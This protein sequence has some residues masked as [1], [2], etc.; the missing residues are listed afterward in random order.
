[1]KLAISDVNCVL[2][3]DQLVSPMV[4]Q[5]VGG[6]NCE[7]FRGQSY[8]LSYYTYPPAEVSG[9]LIQGS[10]PFRYVISSLVTATTYFVRVAAVNSVAVQQISLDGEPPD[11]RQWSFPLSVT[12]KD[13]APDAPLAVFLYPFSGTTLELQIQPSTRDGK[14]EGGAA[15]TAFWIDIDTVSTFDSTTKSAPVVVEVTSGSIPELYPGGPRIYY[16][17]GLTTGTRYFVQVKAKN[18][19]GYSRATLAPTPLGPTQHG[20]GPVNVKVSTLTTSPMPIDTATVTWQKPVFNGGLALTSYKV[21]WWRADSQPEVQVIELTWSTLPSEAPFTLAFGG[22]KSEDLQMDVSAENLRNALMNIMVNGTLSVGNVEVSRSTLNSA[23]GYQWT[24][25]FDNVNVNAGDQPLIQLELGAVVG[26]SGVSGRVFEVEPGIAVPVLSSFPGKS[27]VQV[28]VTYHAAASV[29]G[30]FRLSYK[31]SAWSNYLP[32]SVSAANLK[33]ALEALPTVGTVTVNVN[34]MLLNRQPW[35]NGQVWTITYE[36]NVGN[37]PPLVADASKLTPADAFLG[38]KDGDNAV[39]ATGVLCLPGS[40]AGCPGSWPSGIATLEPVALPGE[41]AVDG[42]AQLASPGEAAVDYGFYET[43]DANT[44]TYS[45]PNLTPGLTYLV[46]VTAK[47]ALGL[48]ARA[49]SSP[50]SVTPSQQVPGL[51]TSVSVGVN[52]GV[53]TQL[54]ATWAAPVSDGGSAVRM[55]RVE[56]DPSPLFTNR[57]QQDAWCPVAPTTAVWRVQTL[58]TSDAT[59]KEIASGYFQL[60]LTRNNAL[61]LSEPIPWN[62][63]ALARDEEG[64]AVVTESGVFCTA[65]SPTC[66][67]NP[68]FPFGRLEKSGSM[69]SKVQYFTRISD[70]VEVTRSA[71]A[72]TDGGFTWSITFLDSGDDFALTVSNVMLACDDPLTCSTA[73][74]NVITTKVR[75]GVMPP[76]CVGSRVLPAVGAL[77][78]GQLYNVRVSAYNV[79]GFGQPAVAPAPQKPM[80]VPGLPTAVTLAVLSVSEL[81]VLF[82]PP[83]DDGGDTVTGYEVQWAIDAAFTTPSS[84]IV[85][86][87]TGVSAPYRRVISSL[88]KGMRYYVRLR[89]SNS[90]GFGQF[91]LSSPTALQPYTTPSAP[92]QVA[93]GVTSATMLTVRW[94]PPSDDGGDAIS[95]YVVQWDVAAGFDSLALTT[96]TTAAVSD[97]LQRSYT[98]TML[99]P[100]TLYYVR[101]FAKNRGGQGTPQ[102][103]MP[104]SQMPAVTNPGKPS[105]LTAAQT[106]VAGELLVTWQT[107]RIPFHGLPCAGTLLAP[108]SC[109]VV[110]AVD[111]VFGGTGLEKYIVQYAESSDFVSPIE[112]SVATTSVVLSSLV[113]AKTYYVQVL[114]VNA[115]GLRSYFC[116]RADTQGQLCP[117]QLVLEDGTVVTGAFVSA[118]PL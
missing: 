108:G 47:N 11:N 69:Q 25:T 27:E 71:T 2:E 104:A 116:K 32:A 1:T 3:V 73:T 46:A 64:S 36:S 57:G 76:N 21:E 29:G 20:G 66:T 102:T 45:I 22:G 24:V 8:S 50:S 52:P 90:Q 70:G 23:P 51:P 5:V 34:S 59:T 65:A 35:M 101:V 60:T 58:R 103:T 112:T 18:S 37:L 81:V 42:V 14:G 78:K 85:L 9:A 54:L 98:L 89:A 72:A 105:T 79:V 43:L 99:T 111:M 63:E 31:G 68:V 67:S 115:Q 38:V 118:Q 84:N 12:T 40:D 107:P 86:M 48:G 117:D 30:Y 100:G 88:T 55:Y 82:S 17:T 53:A 33:L 16:L 94:A 92:T 77:N 106:L 114:T 19:V 110:G 7:N 83:D 75:A 97:P 41:V 13:R 93:L 39:D 28:L 15:I 61:E 95:G 44:L 10:P 49:H 91:Q 4:V 87:L 26:G 6:Y 96:S 80:V 109:P 56:F 74:Y 62:A 113:S